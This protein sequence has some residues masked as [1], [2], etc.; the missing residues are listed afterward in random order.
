[1]QRIIDA[2]FICILTAIFMAS[3]AAAED[4]L[5]FKFDHRHSGNVPDR[6]VATPLGL[7]GTVPLS[8]AVFTAPAIADG[9]AYVVDGSGVAYAIDTKTLEVVWKYATAG[10]PANCNNV[11]SPAIV[12]GYL[13]FGTTAGSYYVLDRR[14]GSLVK[15]IRSSGPIFTAP[16]SAS[17]RVYFATLDARVYA[18]E[19]DGTVCWTWD[20]VKE[21][22]GFTGNPWSGEE[23]QRFKDGRVTW[24]DH[25]CCSRNIAAYD[26]VVVI[27]AGGRTVFL[28]DAGAEPK[29]RDVAEIPSNAGREYA[30]AFGQSIGPD[31]GVY[32]QWHRRDNAGRV[33]ILKLND[34]DEVEAGFVPG[35]QTAINLPGLLSFCSV[36][37]RGK[38]VYRCRP[39]G[40][41]G[42]CL[43]SPEQEEPKYLGGYPSIAAPILLQNHGVYGGLDGSLCVVPLTGEG[44]TWS[45]K[46]A[47]GNAITAPVAVC[48]GRIYFGCEDGYLYILGPDGNASLPTDD[49]ELKKTRS[50]LAGQYADPKY[51]W[52]TNYGDLQN[53]NSNEQGIKPPVRIKWI[54]RYKGTFKHLP[55]CGGGRMYTHTAEGQIFA[56]EQDTGR[57]LWRRYWPGVYLSFTSPIYYRRDGRECLLL[58]Q[59]GLNQSR[60]RCLDAATGELMWEA[61]FTGSPSWSRQAPPIIHDNLAFYA[62]GS[63][64]YAPQGT[65]KAFVMKGQP[66]ESASGE[67]VMSWVYTHNNPYYPKDNAPLIWAWDMDTGKL[68][69]RKDLS[70]HGTGGNDCGLC[71]MDGR[72]YYSTFF[73]YSPDQRK[74]RGLPS[75]P[76]GITASLDPK[77]GDV[78]WVS[79]KHYVTAG[80]TIS[81]KDGRLYVGG[82]NRPDESTDNRYVFCLDAKD[83]SLI[84]QSEPV[85]SAVNVVTI[86]KDY[87]FSN[88]SGRDGHVFDRKT[89]KIV[90]RFNFGYACTRFA[91]SGSYV[92]GA[93][94][95]MIDL[96]DENRLVS[97]GPCIDSRECVGSV[98]S[99]GRI[100]YTSQASGLQVSQVA[101]KEAESAVAPWER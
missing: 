69:W 53:T 99:N 65:D 24:R 10:G 47:F 20:F 68:V 87:I 54:R 80:C 8:D 78:S 45:F 12:G 90:S 83:G 44:D 29:L 14:D 57:L 4:W 64:R 43:H 76:N 100:F 75:G 31:G 98:V 35:T 16:V 58:P 72:L 33:D 77:T 22:M 55:V 39:E 48:D 93:N 79:T 88:A 81:G 6:S 9:R 52:F 32:V 56:V 30:A 96:S 59:A 74:R 25:F 28:E 3:P 37:I 34:K 17:G 51:D 26:N 23:W 66:V 46:T 42:F 73:G 21:V 92:L 70:E 63:G 38:D 84:W 50:P 13:H 85:R 15:E 18:V 19:P 7:V 91:S 60:M 11:S 1:M 49:L 41:F 101:G 89:G 94:M 95:D 2:C 86:G 71:L 67:E 27:P 36:S 61:P 62:S 82:Y 40:G 97:T 5:Q